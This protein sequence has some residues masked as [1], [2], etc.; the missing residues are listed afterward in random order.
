[1]YLYPRPAKVFLS[2]LAICFVISAFGQE[3]GAYVIYNQ[4]GKKTSYRKLLRE[5]QQMDVILFGEY[6][7]NPISHWL[8][9]ELAQD[10]HDGRNL[11]LGAEMLEADNQK[12]LNNYFTGI[13]DEAGLDT[14]ARLWS[15]YETD[16]APLVDFA[17]DEQL[18]FIATNIPRRYASMVYKE[19]GFEALDKLAEYEKRWIAPL[20]ITFDPDLPQYQKMLTM[21]EGH[22]TPELVMAQAIKDATM[23]HFILQN[24]Q[25]GST[26][27]HYN[28]AFHS[29]F[30]EGILWYL[31]LQQPNLKYLTI[32]TVQQS[33]I[34]TLESE[35]M[36]RADF[37]ICVDEDMT[38]T[39]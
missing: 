34:S 31:K 30:H 36:G 14:L 2:L 12:A 37:I 28:G 7:D 24:Y 33:D 1:M 23:A 6:H 4:K 15:N 27:L 13:I 11:V 20:P 38:K 3:D 18:P 25:P 39:Y 22:G 10:L 8:E 29:D 21:M 9:F 35:H 16:Y 5:A 17:K 32:T 26:F 19:G